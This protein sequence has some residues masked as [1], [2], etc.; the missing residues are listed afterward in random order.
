MNREEIQSSRNTNTETQGSQGDKLP[1]SKFE[2]H[3]LG[4]LYHCTGHFC[5]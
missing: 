2:H 5:Q 1:I 4:H 3:G